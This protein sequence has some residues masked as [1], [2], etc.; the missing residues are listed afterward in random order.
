MKKS[1]KFSIIGF[2]TLV[3]TTALAEDAFLP[4]PDLTEQNLGYQLQRCSAFYAAFSGVLSEKILE[5][6]ELN[7]SLEVARLQNLKKRANDN[8]DGLLKSAVIVITV[9]EGKSDAEAVNFAVDNKDGYAIKYLRRFITS[10][11]T[12][13]N[14]LQD[15]LW[16]SDTA[17]CHALVSNITPLLKA[18]V[19]Q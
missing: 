5:S 3:S 16:K 12:L 8:S 19:A 17:S 10:G 13:S 18:L 2:V 6:N 1:T 9:M 7:D 15:N 14:P 11:S 4:L